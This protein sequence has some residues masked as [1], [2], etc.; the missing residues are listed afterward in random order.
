M[1]LQVHRIPDFRHDGYLPDGM[2]LASE[3]ESTFRFGT[4]NRRRRRLVI[5]VRRW[6]ELARKIKARRLFFQRRF[7]RSRL[8]VC[9]RLLAFVRQPGELSRYG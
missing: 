7:L 2:F 1:E 3:A 9:Q 8:L 6:I 4:S 5:R